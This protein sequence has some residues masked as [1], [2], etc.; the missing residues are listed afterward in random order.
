M[1][2]RFVPKSKRL[3]VGLVVVGSATLLA[4][5]GNAT[6]TATESPQAEDAPMATETPEADYAAP[7]ANTVIDIAAS[8]AEFSTLVQAIEAADLTEALASSTPITVFAPTNDAF[9]ALPEGALEALLQPENQDA[10]RQ[11][12]TYHV[13]PMEVPAA[14]VSTGEVPTAAGTPL[15][16]QVDEATGIVMVNEA[17]VTTPDIMASNGVIHA[18]DQV[19]LPPDLAL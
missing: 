3:A 4:A 10:L 11:V 15:V 14:A 9:E 7:G 18:I 13:L 17:Q 5:C 16:L 1:T 12:L 2:H 8:E 6:P 19:I